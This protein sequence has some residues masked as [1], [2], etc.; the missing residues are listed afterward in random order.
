MAKRT[1]SQYTGDVGEALVFIEMLEAGCAVNT[2]SASD[3]G[4]DL[5]LHL[6]TTPRTIK[7][8]RA[9]NERVWDLS[10]RSAHVQV[11]RSEVDK[12]PSLRVGTVRG[13]LAASVAGTPTFVVMSEGNSFTFVTP[14][15]YGRWL[16][17]HEDAD[18]DALRVLNSGRCT[19]RQEFFP[20]LLHLWSRYP[21]VILDLDL[22]RERDL[23]IGG[24]AKNMLR[25]LIVETGIG[26][27]YRFKLG[28]DDDGRT[29]RDLAERFSSALGSPQDPEANE[30]EVQKIALNMSSMGSHAGGL[31]PTHYSLASELSEVVTDA[32][33]M[34]DAFAIYGWLPL[35]AI[36]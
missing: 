31:R 28:R 27:A 11:K 25:E 32:Q 35:R 17:S 36:R 21:L 19:Y 9:L 13:W 4:W 2:L 20:F 10:G 16:R 3:T 18:D 1:L 26:I 15:G 30:V 24:F 8:L 33:Q 12:P 34:L 23:S 29:W 7:T 6:A 5:H 22:T 14:A